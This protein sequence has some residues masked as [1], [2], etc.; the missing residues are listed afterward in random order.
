VGLGLL[1][2]LL[3][4]ALILARGF[5]GLYGQ[6]AFAYHDYALALRESLARHQAPPHFNW[7][8]GY[9]ALELL[10]ATLVGWTPHAGQLASSLSGA[11]VVVMVYLLGHELCRA[12]GRTEPQARWVG[13]VAAL[14]TV[15]CGQL[16]Q[17]SIAVMADAPALFWATLGAWSLVRHGR[18]PG[19]RGLGLAA[20]ALALAMIT[21]WA[22]ALLVVP[23]ALHD[24]LAHRQLP[25]QGPRARAVRLTLAGLAGVLV[26]LPQ[27]WLSSLDPAPL[28]HHQWLVAWSPWHAF[29][30]DFVTVDGHAV[31]PLPVAVFYAKAGASPRFL[32]PLFTPFLLLGTWALWQRRAWPA[33]A[34]LMGWLVAGYGF[35]CGIPCENFRFTLLLLP[36]LALLAA[37]G[38]FLAWQR[39]GPRLRAGLLVY[40]AIG[41][42]GGLVYSHRVLGDFIDRKQSDVQVARWAEARI[43]AG[44]RVLSFGLTLTLGHYTRL[45]V[46]DLFL[47]SARDL[48]RMSRQEE[49]PTYV[50]VD[51]AYLQRQWWNHSPGQHFRR[52]QNGPGLLE[53]GG[54]NGY[55]LFRLQR[56]PR[57]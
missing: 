57:R 13:T 20:A 11:G 37:E 49:P 25:V 39:L 53:L 51:V 16:W 38:L 48:D 34:L 54:L 32:F 10:L 6:D 28:L 45:A 2:L 31:Y 21:R 42:L 8:I 3:Y 14:L 56:P 52:L 30:R 33:L 43:G 27:V 47:L 46:S 4:Q 15:G 1:A 22:Y 40:V 50:V 5:D 18:G 55:T 41:V 35:L 9:P 26:L 36:P 17:W 44:G 24:W 12:D 7:P 19:R 29:G 23:F